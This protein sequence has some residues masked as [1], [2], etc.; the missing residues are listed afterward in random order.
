MKILKNSSKLIITI[1]IVVLF[2]FSYNIFKGRHPVL[3]FFQFL[4]ARDY[5]WLFPLIAAVLLSF[6]YHDRS[7]KKKII[8]ERIETYKAT[9]RTIQD[10]LQNSSSSMQLLILD[11]KESSVNEEIILRAEKNIEELRTV[12]S[13]L[14]TV[15]PLSIQLEE[16][17][18]K[19]SIIKMNG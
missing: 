10:I 1:L 5:L 6:W 12:I 4:E 9:I 3:D 13:T 14:S 18:K 15:D 8:N 2:I 16:L 7:I 19:V 11:M 17:N